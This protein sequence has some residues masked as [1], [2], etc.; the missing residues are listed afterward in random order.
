MALVFICLL[1]AS[2]FVGWFGTRSAT[3]IHRTKGN[4]MDEFLLAA[5]CWSP[6]V[7]WLFAILLFHFGWSQ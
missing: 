1:P 7:I 3:Y 4:R 2:L 5:L 6:L